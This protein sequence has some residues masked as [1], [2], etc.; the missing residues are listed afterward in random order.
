MASPLTH[1]DPRHL[2][3]YRLIARLG[4]GGMGT[5]YL[6]RSTD[7]ETVALKTMHAEFAERPDFRTRFRL[8]TDAARV[9]G[10]WHGARVVDAD[11][12][13][14]VPWL[15]TE[16]VLGPPLD[17]AVALCG[18]LPQEAARALGAAL[19]EALA[20][21]HGTGV[22]HRDL[23]PSN[24]LVTATGPKVIDF[25]IAR[26]L[27]DDRLTRTG[28][29]AGT[30]AFMSPEQATGGEHSPAGDVFALA[31]VLVFASS[32]HGPFG[33]GQPA[34]LL[35]RVRYADP[36]LSGVPEP[37]SP[38]LLRC[39]AKDPAARPDT[40]E[41]RALLGASD[42]TSFADSLP[43]ALLA[44]ILRRGDAVWDI[45]YQRLPAPAP[46]SEP[47]SE[48]Q[49]SLSRRR[50]LMTG[51]G[52]LAL[53]AAGGG[54]WLA[55][56]PDGSQAKAGPS[57]SPAAGGKRRGGAPEEK[58]KAKV[59]PFESLNLLKTGPYDSTTGVRILTPG[60][61]V[62]YA[63]GSFLR[64]VDVRTGD[65]S[66]STSELFSSNT[67]IVEYGSA[68]YGY[69]PDKGDL[70]RVD[71]RTCA[72]RPPLLTKEK[73]RLKKAELQAVGE[74]SLYLQETRSSLL[75]KDKAEKQKE[76][77]LEWVAA[78]LGSGKVRWRRRVAVGYMLPKLAGGKLVL[79]DR[80][81]LL[82]LNARTGRKAWALDFAD[83]PRYDVASADVMAAAG[84]HVFVGEQEI[85]A[86]RVADGKIAWSFGK[87]RPAA[88]N[89][90][91]GE[92]IYG[93][94]VVRD[95]VLYVLEEGHGV[96]AI[97]A[98]TG[99]LRWELRAGWVA[100]SS[101]VHTPVIGR[102]LAYFPGGGTQWIRAVDL[103]RHKEAWTYQGPGTPASVA[104]RPHPRTRQLIAAGGGHL[105]A[106][107]LD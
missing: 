62:A 88:R 13:A 44:E 29:A 61:Y 26:A 93:E 64:T 32:G 91:K 21:L 72:V 50:A 101:L 1:D 107:P 52:V 82:A 87:G 90:M 51:G 84:P 25:G 17:E 92:K 95:G 63:T 104:L 12:L 47:G 4:S 106:L 53:A 59:G 41:L 3:A 24:I 69:V 68:L 81:K 55:L 40:A 58:W 38:V 86:V 6:A 66:G 16:Y 20:Q 22:V 74:G 11:P 105:V 36:D 28:A 35:Y 97:D 60:E 70:A 7:G 73:A 34:D 46:E 57:K 30:P 18:P 77:G 96:L 99:K 89:R 42:A 27:G 43:D 78:D 39:L 65:E 79:A 67:S 83:H 75:D 54:T 9:I 98:E 76:K 2:G 45:Q 71:L 56:R 102:E 5:V 8:E 49:G 31:G 103:R 19:C 14:E 23:K 48:A 10:E 80:K 37:L 85:V 100:H 15:A 33:G 94:R